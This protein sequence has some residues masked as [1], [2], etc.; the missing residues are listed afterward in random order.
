M[1]L[2]IVRFLLFIRTLVFWKQ[3]FSPGVE[4]LPL[5]A[6]SPM[7]SAQVPTS[8]Q[9]RAHFSK[10][11]KGRRHGEKPGANRIPADTATTRLETRDQSR[12]TA[13]WN[14]L[15]IALQVRAQLL[16]PV[17]YVRSATK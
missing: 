6:V 5:D 9:Q 10:H 15:P 11:I 12:P 7:R 17:G 2:E 14:L 3:C 16:D 13:Q 4:L 8:T 1:R